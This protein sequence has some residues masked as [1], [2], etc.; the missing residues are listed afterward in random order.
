MFFIAVCCVSQRNRLLIIGQRLR[1]VV[2]VAMNASKHIIGGHLLFNAAVV[3]EILYH[4]TC[5]RIRSER[6]TDRILSP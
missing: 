1:I 5:Q 3:V 4:F 6:L 2:K